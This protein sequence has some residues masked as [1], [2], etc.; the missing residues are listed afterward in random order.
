MTCN[1]KS[2]A[3]KLTGDDVRTLLR[4]ACDATGSIRAWSRRHAI[5]HAY[6]HQVIHGQMAPGQKILSALHLQRI[7]FYAADSQ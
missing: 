2:S 4:N 3:K 5:S 6:V 1:V 7:I